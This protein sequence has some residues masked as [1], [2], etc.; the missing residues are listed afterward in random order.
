LLVPVDVPCVVL[1]E[2]ALAVT[3]PLPVVL[4]EDETTAPPF[5]LAVDNPLMVPD[6][7]IMV[8]PVAFAED[9]PA[10]EPLADTIE[11]CCALLP[12]PLATDVP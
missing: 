11:S 5:A 4:P 10:E 6:A 2:F 9:A 7:I 12:V 8:L 3:A 1:T